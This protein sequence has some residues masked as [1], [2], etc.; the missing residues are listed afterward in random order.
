MSLLL[1][2][3]VIDYVTSELKDYNAIFINDN[4]HILKYF[5][6]VDDLVLFG[7]DEVSIQN[8]INIIMSGLKECGLNINHGKS[9]TMNLIIH[10]KK[11]SY[12]HLNS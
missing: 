6:F 11:C 10:P 7:K 8:L 2:N 4:I 9:A 1:F 3:S 12:V 5:T